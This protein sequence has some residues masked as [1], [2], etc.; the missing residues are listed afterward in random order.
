M[1]KNNAF[2]M[3]LF[4]R[5]NVFP[6]HIPRLTDRGEDILLLSNHFIETYSQ[7]MNLPPTSLTTSGQTFLMNQPWPGNIR[8]LENTIQ[9][10]VIICNGKPITEQILSYKPGQTILQPQLPQPEPSK[11]R[12]FTPHHS[13]K[14]KHRLSNKPWITSMETSKK[15]PNN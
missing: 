4:Y 10:A 6:I 5:I 12:G 2:R 14:M 3:D 13:I 15:Q 9:R 1:V 7:K 11:A 8:E